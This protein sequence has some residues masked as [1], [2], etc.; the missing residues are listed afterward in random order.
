MIYHERIVDKPRMEL[1]PHP[2]T[3]R[4]I[5]YRQGTLTAAE[6]DAV[7]EHLSLCPRCTGLLR[8]LRELEAAVE[9]G[10]PAPDPLREEAWASLL[11]KLPAKPPAIRPV[12]PLPRSRAP[13]LARAASIVGIA[14][15]LVAVIGLALLFRA[16]RQQ[17][18]ARDQTL[19]G[20]RLSLADAGRQ[21]DAAHGRIRLLEQEK[22]SQAAELNARLEKLRRS[23]PIPSGERIADVGVSLSPRF[24]LRGEEPSGDDVL[25]GG[26]ETN[27]ARSRNGSFTVGLGPSETQVFPEIRLE[28]VDR[29]GKVVWSGRRPGESLGDDGA[30]LTIQGLRPGRYRLRVEGLQPNRTRFLGEYALDVEP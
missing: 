16:E 20:L 10:A 19:A 26:G 3:K 18:A 8:E 24:V 30:S 5:A 6:R 1:T 7:Q 9:S 2:G 23:A 21:L 11:Q 13:Y 29:N 25:R 14:A 15:L 17:L 22:A 28:I 4:L 27:R 12:A